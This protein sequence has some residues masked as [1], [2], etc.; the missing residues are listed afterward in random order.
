MEEKGV[1]HCHYSTAPT[2]LDRNET[3]S[4]AVAGV[5]EAARGAAQSIVFPGAFIP[6]YLAWI[7]RFRPGGDVALSERRHSLLLANAV[8]LDGNHLAPL[9]ETARQNEV[10]IVCCIDE[11]DT[12]FS[13]RTIY[14]TGVVIEPNRAMVNRHRKVMPT[15]PES[16]VWGSGMRRNSR[17]W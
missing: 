16:M 6:G 2:F 14:N 5:R 11:R 10:T 13:R 4:D 7:W 3:I 8:G 1:G 17:R 9:R 15:T 12:E